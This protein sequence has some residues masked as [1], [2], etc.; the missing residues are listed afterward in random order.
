MD[1]LPPTPSRFALCHLCSTGGE[2]GRRELR[3][4]L[5]VCL[6]GRPG[7]SGVASYWDS[8]SCEE[9][10]SR[11]CFIRGR[12]C[13]RIQICGEL[14]ADRWTNRRDSTGPGVK[15]EEGAGAGVG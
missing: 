5:V 7:C 1:D 4:G 3:G 11:D 8:R 2:E 15:G 10:G 13:G 12:F 14:M 9:E 6:V